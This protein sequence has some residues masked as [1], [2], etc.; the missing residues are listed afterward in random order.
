MIDD[1]IVIRI[2]RRELLLRADVFA[3]D[4]DMDRRAFGNVG[5]EPRYAAQ[6][7]QRRYRG[8]AFD[9]GGNRTDAAGGDSLQRI[10]PGPV[11]P[12]KRIADPLLVDDHPAA[13][14]VD[15][16]TRRSSNRNPR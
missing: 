16:K 5:D 13:V 3:V 7:G 12:Q 11:E 14:V 15:A 9:H 10:L 6:D 4:V 1:P 8:P 2:A